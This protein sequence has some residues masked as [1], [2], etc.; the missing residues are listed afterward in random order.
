MWWRTSRIAGTLPKA[1]RACNWWKLRCKAGTSGA[2][3]TFQRWRSEA[4]AM[5]LSLTLPSAGR[6]LATYTLRGAVPARSSTNIRFNRIAYSAA[7]VVADAR[8]AIDPWVQCA[9]DWDA[10]IAY[11]RHLWSLGLG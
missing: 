2:G 3:S 10:T 11:R 4:R 8:A 9:I 6:E 7:H 1:P 5:A